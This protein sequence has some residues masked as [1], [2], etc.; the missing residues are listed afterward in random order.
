MEFWKMTE[1]SDRWDQGDFA[2]SGTSG[3]AR[4]RSFGSGKMLCLYLCSSELFEV[5]WRSDDVLSDGN[6]GNPQVCQELNF[7]SFRRGFRIWWHNM[8]MGKIWNWMAECSNDSIRQIEFPFPY[9]EGQRDLVVSVYR[10]ILR[11]KKLF[12]QAPT[13]VGKTM[14]TVF[15]A[16]RA[17]GEGLGEKIFIWQRRRLRGQLQSRH[18]PCWKKRGCCIRPLR[19]RQK[20][21]SVFVRRQSAIRM[22]VLMQKDILTE[23]MM[24]FLIWSHIPATGAERFWKNRRKAHGLSVRDVSGCVQLAD[25]VICD[26]NYA[27][28]PQ[29][30]LKRFSQKVEKGNTCFWSMRRIIWWSGEGRCIVHLYTKKIYWK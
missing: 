29:A 16:V 23:W 19:W 17:V 24:Q 6:R 12:I 1:K 13:G 22:P 20:K 5:H 10:T 9:R 28:D 25:A 15:P 8:K 7:K 4:S 21:K 14:A 2:K 27:F 18:F 11:K 3:S 30:H 26:Y